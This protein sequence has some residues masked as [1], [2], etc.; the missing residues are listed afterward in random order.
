MQ[1]DNEQAN[2]EVCKNMAVC[3]LLLES[4]FSLVLEYSESIA[5]EIRW[6]KVIR[7]VKTVKRK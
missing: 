5:C 2:T 3:F 7:N 6:S 4:R 1:I